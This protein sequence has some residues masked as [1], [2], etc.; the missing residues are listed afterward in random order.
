[1]FSHLTRNAGLMPLHLVNGV[2]QGD[3][4]CDKF[5]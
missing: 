3:N 5:S 2:P 1:M 4:N